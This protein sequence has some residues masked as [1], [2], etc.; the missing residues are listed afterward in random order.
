LAGLKC[1]QLSLEE[2]A[3]HPDVDLVVIATSGKAGLSPTLAAVRA[4][5]T[6]ALANKEPL[7][8]AGETVTG[9][10]KLSGAQILP[11]DSEHSAIW[12]CLSGEK[13]KA[14]RIIL[15]ASGGPFRNYSLAQLREV[16]VEQALK[17]PTWRMGRK[18]TIDSATLMNKGLEV[19]EAHWL[20]N[21][22]YDRIE[23]LVHPQCIIHSMV[24]FVD[25][26][27]KAQL[28]YPDMRLPIQYAL[29]Y[30][31]RLANIRLP[32]VD[33]RKFSNLTFEPPNHEVFPCLKLAI[34]AG[35]R[36]GTYPTVLCAVDEVAVELFLSRRV[37]FLDI[38]R[39]VE[40][41]LEKHVST[42]RPTIEEMWA[43]DAWA[44][45]TALKLAEGESE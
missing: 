14:V 34:E 23:V 42:A 4:G 41:T 35:R 2:I 40:L 24:E 8:M 20:F 3:C 21:M 7:V 29:S 6:I 32:K 30:P 18:V 38:P 11:I 27:I 26:S 43:A 16:T 31:G 25:G 5:K 22:P 36:G 15:A 37:R 44:R 33:W 19:I 9:E 17:H 28:S 13:Q 10:A 39:L 1:Q 45:E 12:Q